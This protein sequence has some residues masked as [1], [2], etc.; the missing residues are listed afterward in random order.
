MFLVAILFVGY[1]NGQDADCVLDNQLGINRNVNGKVKSISET[2]YD[3]R[4]KFG[5]I[6][7]GDKASSEQR[8]Y[9][10]AGRLRECINIRYYTTGGNVNR[11]YKYEYNNK[12][13]CIEVLEY[14]KYSS[15]STIKLYTKS[16]FKY[17]EEGRLIKLSIYNDKGDILIT[18]IYEY[19]SDN[20]LA[21]R[22]TYGAYNLEYNSDTKLWESKQY[23]NGLSGEI[24]YK[25]DEKGFLVE[26]NYRNETKDV[27]SYN[28]EKINKIS[29]DVSRGED[30]NLYPL[31]ISTYN[32]YGDCVEWKAF[33]DGSG[34]Y[35]YQYTYDDKGNWI[36]T[37][38]YY[39]SP[40][41]LPYPHEVRVRKIGYW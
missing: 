16:I 7:F 12:G 38:V 24:T 15:D 5:E 27:Y 39:N 36:K 1:I 41:E 17:D 6:E 35:S 14:V 25:Y 10:N 22:K 29:H 26:A 32:Q 9:D 2:W 37:V 23:D 3:A 33:F 13:A 11:T 19:N 31:S 28:N 34:T 20:K 21:V 4:D 8:K 30:G 40:N 18:Y